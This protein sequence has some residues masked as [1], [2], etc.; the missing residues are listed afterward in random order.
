M[1]GHPMIRGRRVAS[2]WTRYHRLAHNSAV[3]TLSVKDLITLGRCTQPPEGLLGAGA[4]QSFDPDTVDIQSHV[5]GIDCIDL[6]Y[7]ISGSHLPRPGDSVTGF[8]GRVV[9]GSWYGQK[10]ANLNLGGAF[11]R[12]RI[13]LVRVPSQHH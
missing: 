10:P 4:T 6:A 7:E 5:Q 9:I 13:Q 1:D 12:S 8:G 2:L 11:H 3:S